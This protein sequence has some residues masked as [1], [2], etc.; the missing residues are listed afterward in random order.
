MTIKPHITSA[1]LAVVLGFAN[2]L[3]AQEKPA[4]A[5]PYPTLNPPP[6]ITPA[7][8]RG[9]FPWSFPNC[10]SD[11]P[12]TPGRLAPQ[13][14]TPEQRQQYEART[15]WFHEAKFGIFFHFLAFGDAAKGM[16][17]D[18]FWPKDS[19]W[20]SEEWNKVVDEVDVEKFADLAKELG[21][22]YVVISLGQ[23]H[24]YAC[25]PN[26][27]IDELWGL[28]PGQYNSRRDL[29]M[30]LGKALEKRGI[31][32]MLYVMVQ[33]EHK[34]PTPHGWTETDKCQ[35]WLKVIQY[36]SDHYGTL[37]KGWWVDGLGTVDQ[38]EK[39]T[40]PDGYPVN[41]V[42]ALKHGNPDALVA[43]G[44]LE[45]SDYT[46]GHCRAAR[47]WQTQRKLSRPF[48]GRWDPDA[49]IQWQSLLYLGDFWGGIEANKKT[50]EVVAYA[51]DIVKGGGVITF[52]VGAYKIVDGK[53]IPCL[54]IPEAQRAQLR[55]VRDAVRDIPVSDGSGR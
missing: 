19:D 12:E 33:K 25:A 22:G 47:D 15:K 40:I 1:A 53:T 24:Q 11:D 39:V 6:G 31:P 8:T 46:H 4:A 52:D 9:A 36:Y 34:L 55:A 14:W 5:V 23:W 7:E 54:D 49:R 3:F 35:N 20:T 28:K 37:C 30:E 41:M 10:Y 44:V 42:K 32:M 51:A 26:P 45:L 21:V 29:P 18:S 13:T 43:C 38:L 50:E 27:V 16:G 17:R 48:F 2:G